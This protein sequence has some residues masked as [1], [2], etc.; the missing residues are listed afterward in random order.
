MLEVDM[1][2]NGLISHHLGSSELGELH[3]WE[4]GRV[5]GDMSERTSTCLTCCWLREKTVYQ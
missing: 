3:S 5:V 2:K 4:G 1:V